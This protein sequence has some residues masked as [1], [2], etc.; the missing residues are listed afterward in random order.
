[1]NTFEE[2]IDSAYKN[3]IEVEEM[4][5]SDN[6]K[7]L[8]IDNNIF[9]E[10]YTT[11]TEKR[12]I[13]AEE[14][15]HH[16]TGFGDAR[17]LSPLFSII[18]ERWGRAWAYNALIPPSILLTAI[19]KNFPE[20]VYELAEALNVTEKFLTETIAYYKR[21]YGRYMKVENSVIDLE[22]MKIIN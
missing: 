21:K 1:M 4:A 12:C 8:Y 15:G 2:L 19:E 13:L 20:Y 18:Q 6:L 22:R 14:L 5:F 10:K 9:L 3:N 7:G 17:K 11:Q 16:F